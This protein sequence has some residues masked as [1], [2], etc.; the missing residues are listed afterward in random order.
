M[1]FLEESRRW[2]I[3]LVVLDITDESRKD[4]DLVSMLRLPIISC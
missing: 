1:A 2:E 3:F 4:S